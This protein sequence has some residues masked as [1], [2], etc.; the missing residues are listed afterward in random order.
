MPRK[1]I[2]VQAPATPIDLDGD[3][4]Q[5]APTWFSMR[6]AAEYC[7][8]K[9]AQITKAISGGKLHART[10]EV[11][12]DY[13]PLTEIRKAD[14]DV[15]NAPKAPKATHSGARATRGGQARRWLLY[16]PDSQIDAIK[17]A[18]APFG[19]APTTAYRNK[20]QQDAA[21]A[22]PNAETI[23]ANAEQ[24]DTPIDVSTPVEQDAS[25]PASTSDELD[26]V[27]A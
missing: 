20:K 25:A 9:K 16:V 7:G 12:P 6:Q 13:P 23:A 18:L 24:I 14:L 10:R 5:D 19:I 26:L 3:S 27:E 2:P 15:W 4:A 22:E 21:N 1:E 8:K 11:H 17:A